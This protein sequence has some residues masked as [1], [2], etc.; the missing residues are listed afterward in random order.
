MVVAGGLVVVVVVVAGGTVDGGVLTGG[1]SVVVVVG[2]GS[3]VVVG[4]PFRAGLV[5]VVV[6]ALVVVVT[7]VVGVEVGVLRCRPGRGD[8]G[9]VLPGVEVSFFGWARCGPVDPPTVWTAP[10]AGAW[11]RDD[12]DELEDVSERRSAVIEVI[13]G[14]PA[15]VE[16][17]G[18]SGRVAPT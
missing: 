14:T 5:V 1:G 9:T 12:R 16:R 15:P 7:L 10:P 17:S 8:E 3:V 2:N 4:G 13:T 6:G 18:I 11:D